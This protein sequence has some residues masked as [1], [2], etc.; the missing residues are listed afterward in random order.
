MSDSSITEAV[1][2]KECYVAFL[3]ILGFKKLIDKSECEDIFKI[4]H[5]VLNFEPHPLVSNSEVYNNIRYTIMSDSIVVYIEVEIEDS[6]IALA[7]VCSQIQMKLS[8]NNP[9]IFLR[10]GISQGTLYHKERILFGTGLTKAY[11]LENTAAI[12]PRIIFM[13]RKMSTNTKKSKSSEETLEKLRAFINEKGG[14]V[15]KE[16]FAALDVDYRKILEFVY[17]RTLEEENAE[18][19][20]RE[21]LEARTE[22]QESTA[23]EML[24]KVEFPAT[25]YTSNGELRSAI[26]DYALQYVGNRYVHGGSSLA[27]GTDCSGFTCFVYADFGYSISRTRP[28]SARA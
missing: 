2:Y 1:K 4:F 7:D 11:I 25:S 16:E 5:A 8:R 17:A 26:V 6:F 10:G 22:E 13:E 27:T 18:I 21:A 19:A 20:A 23:P 15:K 9:P 3:D 24:T 14:I 28:G 12:Y